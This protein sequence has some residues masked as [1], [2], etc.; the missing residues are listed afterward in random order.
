MKKIIITII[1]LIAI[2]NQVVSQK[3]IDV[4]QNG[5]VVGSMFSPDIDS[6]TVSG[7]DK[8]TR[9]INFW[10]SGSLSNSFAITTVDSIKVFHSEDEPLVYLGILGFNQELYS[11]PI[12]IL[13][14]STSNNFTNF[15]NSLTRKDGT[16][17]YYAVDN[18]L[19]LLLNYNFTTPISSINLITFTDGLDQGSLMMTT[20]FQDEDT[21]LS[22]LNHRIDTMRVR[23]LPVS[24]YSI[25]LRGNDVTDYTQ[26]LS[27]LRLLATS[28][29][30]TIEVTSMSSLQSCL[31]KVADQI[32][33]IS[34]RQTISA[35]IPGQSNETHICFTF[36]G[37]TPEKSSLYIEGVFNLAD[38]TLHNVNYDGI[39]TTSGETVEG[40]QDGI[41]VTFTFTDLQRTDGNGLIPV[42]NIRHYYQAKGSST[43]QINSEFTPSNNTQTTVSH[44]GAA[45]LLVLDC[46]SSLGSLFGN[47][48]NYAKDFIWQL[49]NNATSFTITAPQNVAATLDDN[50]N[51]VVS[52]DTVK[53]AEYYRVYRSKSPN[54]NFTIIA[55][56]IDVTH[57]IDETP[58]EGDNY[59]IIY[60][61]G[62]GLLSSAS[63]IS[64]VVK[65]ELSTPTNVT[66]TFDREEMVVN[67]KWDGVKYADSYNVYR[68]GDYLGEF[69]LIASGVTSSNWKDEAPLRGKNYYKI[70]A[71][72]HGLTSTL[73]TL[74]NVV[75][76]VDISENYYL[77]GGPG[78]WSNSKEQ[79]FLHSDKN[80][81]D[82][83]V[84]I[85]TF[86]STG[87]EMWFAFGDDEA[88]D[89]VGDGVWNKL[90]G[91]TG[92]STDL[93][94][95]F[96]R[97]Y[98]LDGDHS[99]CV[100]GKA[101]YYRFSANMMD[102]T[103][104]I[105]P[106]YLTEFIYVPGN[107][108]KYNTAAPGMPEWG[109]LPE[110]APALCSANFDGIYEGFAYM[111]GDFKFTKE[112]NWND[113]YN[114]Y[115]FNY[116]S[117][118]FIRGDGGNICCT[119]PGYYKLVADVASGS[120]TAT[121]LTWGLVGPATAGGWDASSY[122]V[123]HYN[124]VEDCWEITTQLNADKFR[125]T[126]NGSM[127][128]NLGG[129]SV[130]DLW[131]GGPDL[132]ISE[133]GTYTIKLYPSRTL[134]DKMYATIVKL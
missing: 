63:P 60:A 53:H 131:E 101:R 75:Y 110:C 23:G 70:C 18:A 90:F 16:L 20:N 14:N 126:T 83:P 84:F 26:F 6:I 68:S 22:Y 47:L 74:S 114:Y 108:Q 58:F 42:N 85:Y 30:Y 111:D 46:S 107:A 8:S 50:M 133:A 66:A 115:N 118:I 25:G 73:S 13:A 89:A 37:E 19:D 49:A 103:Y 40:I 72:G 134:S 71:V 28:D 95:Y 67:V 97:R 93:N 76:T 56:S 39:H 121:K 112:R 27:N 99:F 132:S 31:K 32:I 86:K 4:Y 9:S 43:W 36:D 98:K 34:N 82:D 1:A 15:I 119:N 129:D 35:K 87:D 52:W 41:F 45:V 88:I 113:E 122:T 80:V 48:Q 29:D 127:K 109:W 24:A 57:W 55:D 77:I 130:D 11:M 62:H 124:M 117:S 94:G 102:Y 51:I 128:I 91:T 54:S 3:F 116:F 105:T 125:F 79:K 10:R 96:D 78:E 104:E 38:R 17:L 64:E 21:Y 123:M 2:T 61:M 120:L 106:L 33:N 44:S 12:D 65:F 59:Y 100:D 81:Y 92:A 69:S 5:K 7:N